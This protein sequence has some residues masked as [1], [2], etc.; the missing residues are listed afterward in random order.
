[1]LALSSASLVAFDDKLGST[2]RGF[3]DDGDVESSRESLPYAWVLVTD[4]CV[5]AFETSC[6]RDGCRAIEC[7]DA[8]RDEKVGTPSCGRGRGGSGGGVPSLDGEVAPLQE[9]LRE[10][11]PMMPSVGFAKSRCSTRSA[12]FG[13]SSIAGVAGSGGASLADGWLCGSASPDTDI[14]RAA[15]LSHEV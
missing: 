4:S 11:M 2:C 1:M 7:E 15:C 8:G 14:G 3:E 9:V 5:V 10:A 13:A 12:F 6:G